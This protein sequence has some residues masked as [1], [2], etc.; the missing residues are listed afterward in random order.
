[1]IRAAVFDVD[2]TLLD[3][4]PIWEN[5]AAVFLAKYGIEAEAG[6]GR[7]LYPLSMQEGAAYLQEKYR[8][9]MSSDKIIAGV[10][11]VV[12]DFYAAEAPLKPNAAA[13]LNALREKS[14]PMAIA[15]SNERSAVEAAFRRLGILQY[16]TEIFTCSEIGA[17]KTKPDIYQRAAEA[18]QAAPGCTWVF[19]DAY[20]AAKTAH[21]AGFQVAGVYDAS[22]AEESE[23]LRA[24]SDIYI[25]DFGD[26]AGFYRE[27]QR[28]EPK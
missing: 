22:S 10:G 15:T 27:A 6:L 16:F 14:I 4:M 8:L 11:A 1:M 7:R 19:E 17:G 24:V 9:S 25:E 2:G 21:D 28:E 12:S 3:S 13:F 23:L 26:F 18:L 20:Y 5:A